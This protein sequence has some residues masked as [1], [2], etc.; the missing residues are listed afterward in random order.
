MTGS[1]VS[2]QQLNHVSNLHQNRHYPQHQIMNK[3]D[4]SA[5]TLKLDSITSGQFCL[6]W[7]YNDQGQIVEEVFRDK[8]D[9]ITYNWREV[10]S[11]DR[12]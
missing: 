2:A 8:F 7:T 3:S 11:F 10:A 9:P 6:S 1:L 12:R 5:Y 4:A